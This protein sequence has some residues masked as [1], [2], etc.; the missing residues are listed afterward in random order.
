MKLSKRS[1][2]LLVVIAS[3]IVIA[4]IAYYASWTFYYDSHSNIYIGLS[5]SDSLGN[6]SSNSVEITIFADI[7]QTNSLTKFDFVENGDEGLGLWYS[8]N[9]TGILNSSN[10]SA[11]I[12]FHLDNKSPVFHTSIN[13]PGTSGYYMIKRGPLTYQSIG[14]LQSLFYLKNLSKVVYFVSNSGSVEEIEL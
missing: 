7:N 11:L 1:Q 3:L 5:V 9:M 2:K 8:E 4:A 13:L 10:I 12:P 6:N 14:G